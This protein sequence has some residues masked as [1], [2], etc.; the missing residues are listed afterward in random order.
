MVRKKSTKKTKK[1]KKCVD[2]VREWAELVVTAKLLQGAPTKHNPPDETPANQMLK[3][4][5]VFE[6]VQELAEQAGSPAVLL[7]GVAVTAHGMTRY[8][9]DLDIIA[10]ESLVQ[11][12]PGMRVSPIMHTPWQ[13]GQTEIDDMALDCLLTNDEFG[14]LEHAASRAVTICG[15]KVVTVEDLLIL[16]AV[17]GRVKD[18]MDFLALLTLH[19]ITA[20]QTKYAKKWLKKFGGEGLERWNDWLV[21]HSLGQKGWLD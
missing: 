11:E 10:S 1:T 9:K 6:E 21:D 20:A 2:P 14:F 13:V 12:L 5:S 15:R 18:Q 7:G 19:P 4:I 8:T 17:A 16:K 3:L